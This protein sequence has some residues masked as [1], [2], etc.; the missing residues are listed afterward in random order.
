MAELGM[1]RSGHDIDMDAK[2]AR[3]E[4]SREE[5]SWSQKHPL[6][7]GMAYLA[8]SASFAL[9][10]GCGAPP[11]NSDSGLDADT[12][13]CTPA[14]TPCNS[15]DNF[16]HADVRVGDVLLTLDDGF[17]DLLVA[18]IDPDGTIHVSATNSC[19]EN[20]RF[21]I[22]ADDGHADYCPTYARGGC[23]TLDVGSVEDGT[24]SQVEV[25][26]E[27]CAEE[28]D[29][30][31]DSDS[32][33]D[34]DVDIDRTDGDVDADVEADAD[35]T[36]GDADADVEVDVDAEVDADRTD[37]DADADVEADAE[38][39]METDAEVDAE[40]DVDFEVDIDLGDLDGGEMSDGDLDGGDVIVPPVCV[41]HEECEDDQACIDEDCVSAECTEDGTGGTSDNRGETCTP[42]CEARTRVTCSCGRDHRVR[43]TPTDCPGT[44]RCGED[45]A[46]HEVP[47]TC[48]EHTECADDQACIDDDC[49]PAVCVEDGVG[50]TSDNRGTGC[51]PGC[52]DTDTRRTCSC[53]VNHRVTSPSVDC[54]ETQT[55]EEDGACHEPVLTCEDPDGRDITRAT[56]TTDSA[57]R[58]IPDE[59]SEDTFS[60]VDEGICVDN[61]ATIASITCDHG[62]GCVEGACV[63][64]S[65]S[66]Y[67]CNLTP[68]LPGDVETIQELDLGRWTEI[69]TESGGPGRTNLMARRRSSGGHMV[70]DFGP[71]D[72]RGGVTE[73]VVSAA[74]IDMET[75]IPISSAT[76]DCHYELAI[77]PE[78]GDYRYAMRLR[79]M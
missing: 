39:D 40:T 3:I 74:I 32:D 17:A 46:C 20:E 21:Q 71:S 58:S 68:T 8:T 79:V 13:T 65:I 9:G 73:V 76:M 56:T 66:D 33:A 63:E 77:A 11:S 23:I 14:T 29:G 12:P 60:S 64:T 41:D 75:V 34:H 57:G 10:F 52:V 36:D 4:R 25:N 72:G 49:V 47:P 2:R 44:E 27:H 67:F 6:L 24:I 42:S 61:A 53:G 51:V 37:G 59:C 78:M 38:A 30:D 45:G 26:L 28:T 50:G 48:I 18:K 70:A 62:D 31:A 22:A 43:S 1:K 16:Y 19:G 69:F 7:S 35:R 55:C 5:K 15:G 54:P